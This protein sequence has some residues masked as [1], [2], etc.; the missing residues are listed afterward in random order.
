MRFSIDSKYNKSEVVE[1]SAKEKVIIRDIELKLF[2]RIVTFLYLVEYED[3][4]RNW[5]TEDELYLGG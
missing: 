5:L 3:G 4:T 2:N 1:T